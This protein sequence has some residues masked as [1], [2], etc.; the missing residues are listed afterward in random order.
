M[1]LRALVALSRTLALLAEFTSSES[2]VQL[3]GAAGAAV[4]PSPP[5]AV[6]APPPPADGA[7]LFRDMPAKCMAAKLSTALDAD[8]GVP[9]GS[10][11][12]GHLGADDW[13]AAADDAFSKSKCSGCCHL[14]RGFTP[15]EGDEGEDG[16][17]G[18]N[19]AEPPAGKGPGPG[20][21]AGGGAGLA[22]D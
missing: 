11:A 1:P 20:V 12:P 21:V 13:G 5:A 7:P 22:D 4:A 15:A 18:I 3:R 2:F 8:C 17:G 14:T 19:A 10:L 9:W 16:D 6:A